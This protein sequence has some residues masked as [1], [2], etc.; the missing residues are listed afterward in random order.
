MQ[1]YGSALV[2]TNFEHA[3]GMVLNNMKIV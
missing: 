1:K 2:F 3:F